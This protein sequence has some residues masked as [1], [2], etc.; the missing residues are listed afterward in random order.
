MKRPAKTTKAK[1]YVQLA[2]QALKHAVEDL[3]A[4]RHRNG[5]SL[6]IWR[7]GRV[8]RVPAAELARPRSARNSI[9]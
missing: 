2:E 8:V 1:S 6:V 9:S 7:N 3:I 5:G 4:E